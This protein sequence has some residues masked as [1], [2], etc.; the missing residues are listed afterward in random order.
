MFVL[1]ILM[2]G[3]FGMLAQNT[4][5][6]NDIQPIVAYSSDIQNEF[7]ISVEFN[8]S[9]YQFYMEEKIQVEDWMIDQSEW[10]DAS[11]TLLAYALKVE[12]EPD[13]LTES[14]MIQ[15]FSSLSQDWD[16]LTVAIEEPLEVRKWMICCADWN[17]K[18]RQGNWL[19]IPDI[20]IQ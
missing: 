2:A 7:E 13:M 8:V 17:L 11:K 19:K 15:P 4:F 3:P 5:L 9:N 1:L 10:E 16:F 18:T 20:T 14:W 6:I 12:P